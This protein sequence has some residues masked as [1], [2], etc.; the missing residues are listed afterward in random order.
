MKFH[1]SSH[2]SQ[3]ESHELPSAAHWE[4]VR[5]HWFRNSNPELA[6]QCSRLAATYY[7]RLNEHLQDQL[8]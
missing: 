2:R 1:R 4:S 6:N 8:S 7:S 5:A 3:V